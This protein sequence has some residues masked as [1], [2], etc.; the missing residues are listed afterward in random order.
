MLV[1]VG[2]KFEPGFVFASL[3]L[4]FLEALFGFKSWTM[5]KT[6][7]WDRIIGLM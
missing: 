3:S 7:A 5:L 2:S 6:E 1:F 4:S